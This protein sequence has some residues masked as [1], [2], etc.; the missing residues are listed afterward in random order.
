[1]AYY[2]R[3]FSR[4][5]WDYNVGLAPEFFT[6]DAITGCTRTTKNKLSIWLSETDNFNDATVQKLI[7]ALATTMNEPASIDLI[8]LDPDW[9][10]RKGYTIE[11]NT[12]KT[13]YARVNDLHRDIANLNHADLAEVGAHIIERLSVDGAV[14]KIKK[15]ELVSLVHKWLTADQDFS[16]EELSEKWHEPLRK[17]GS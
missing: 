3:K 5:K 13:R 9:F 2:L 14:K 8:W 16:I 7:V 6:A 1:M 15:N 10:D 12:G 17:L 4:A 11:K